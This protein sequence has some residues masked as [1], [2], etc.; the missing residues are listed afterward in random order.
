MKLT[1]E[2]LAACCQCTPERARQWLP[3]LTEAM[4]AYQIDDS[5]ERVAPFLA[6]I[7]HESASLRFTR[8]LWGPTDAQKRYEGRKD[9][10]NTQPGDGYRFRGHG[11]IQTTGRANHRRVRDRLRARLGYDVVPDF[12]LDPASLALPRW[13]ALSAGDYWDDRGLNALADTGQFERITRRIN[14]GL[15]GQEDRVRRWLLAR[16]ALGIA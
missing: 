10:G 8:E 4:G 6:Q 12:E 7:G 14:G 15:N 16:A 11:L 13:A 5:A 9:L 3:F 2:Q 1:A